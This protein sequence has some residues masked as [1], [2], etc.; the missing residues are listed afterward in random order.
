MKTNL[1]SKP[2]RIWWLALALFMAHVAINKWSAFEFHRDEF[3]YLAMGD[4]LQWWRMDFPP[5]MASLANVSR[6]LA[7]DSLV[8][9]RLGPAIAASML[10]LLSAHTAR[11]LGGSVQSQWIA[12]IAVAASPVVLRAGLL[13]QPVIFDQLWWT[14][15]LVALIAREQSDDPRWWIAIGLALGFGLLTK[16][17]IAFVGVGIVVAMIVTPLRRDLRTRWPWIALLIALTIGSASIVGQIRMDYPILWQMR[18]LKAGQLE[19]RALWAFFAEQPTMTGP[20]GFVLSMIGVW[21]MLRSTRAGFTRS[22]AIAMIV[23]WIWLSLS[24]GKGYYGAP[25]YPVA[26]AAGSV[27]V[28]ELARD[29]FRFPVQAATSALLILV[30]LIAFPLA[31]PI[32][33]VSSTASYASRLNM[34]GATRTNYGTTLP[35]PQDFADMLGW[36][37]MAVATSTAWNALSAADRNV[38]V[39]AARNYGEAGALDHYGKRLGLPRVVSGDG[40]YWFFGP[41]ERRGDV[42][43]VLG[44]EPAEMQPLFDTCTRL[45]TVGTEWAVEEERQVPITLC[46]G[47]KQSLQSVWPRFDPS[48]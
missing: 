47:A 39:L 37:A 46:R 2:A 31:L 27:A 16:L 33:S 20:I 21:W 18:D 23:S 44:E 42:L 10:V 17:S 13:F 35:L 5:F 6:A 28:A 19:R 24:R 41:G 43:L 14:C 7:G 32:L 36:K 29:R 38:A 34:T 8:A 11:R 48:R 30:G 3:L 1:S 40:S 25:I 26:L 45:Q 9:I 12:A 4:H 15:A 22:A